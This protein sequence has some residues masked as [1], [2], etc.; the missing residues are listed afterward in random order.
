MVLYRWKETQVPTPWT[1]RRDS[2]YCICVPRPTQTGTKRQPSCPTVWRR[3]PHRTVGMAF[4]R[5]PFERG[6]T[7]AHCRMQE[8]G[9]RSYPDMINISC[10]KV[11]LSQS[12][13]FSKKQTSILIG[14]I[15]ESQDDVLF[16]FICLLFYMDRS[17]ESSVRSAG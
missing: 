16:F 5:W 10:D 1:R 12:G 3:F 17:S 6:V 8:S 9:C 2:V 13:H 4:Q 11:G 7:R 15:Q 14:H